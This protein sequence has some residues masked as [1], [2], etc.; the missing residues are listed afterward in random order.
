MRRLQRLLGSPNQDG[1]HNAP[2]HQQECELPAS[3]DG[4][5]AR[6]VKSKPLRSATIWGRHVALDKQC[7]LMEVRSLVGFVTITVTPWR[8]SCARVVLWQKAPRDRMEAQGG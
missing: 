6:R 5:I 4:S 7:L 2:S 3:A 8:R 1:S